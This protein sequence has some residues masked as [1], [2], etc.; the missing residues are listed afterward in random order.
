MMASVAVALVLMVG[1]IAAAVRLCPVPNATALRGV[2]RLLRVLALACV[3]VISAVIAPAFKGGWGFFLILA[4]IPLACCLGA[5]V[6]DLTGRGVALSTTV[7]ALVLLLW[8]LLTGLGMGFYFLLPAVLL[9]AAASLSSWD[10]KD[11]T[12][13]VP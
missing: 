10:A 4:A 12:R 13:M 1:V 6:A 8:S 2:P 11:V 5:L 3:L 7:A 9:G